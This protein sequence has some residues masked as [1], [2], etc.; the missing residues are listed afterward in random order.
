MTMSRV[1]KLR[2]VA[3]VHESWVLGNQAR[4]S[5]GFDASGR[6]DDSDYNLHHVDID[7]DGAAEDAF[8]AALR[9]LFGASRGRGRR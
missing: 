8:A 7:A 6:K 2:A 1:D 3:D 5:E 4:V 9:G